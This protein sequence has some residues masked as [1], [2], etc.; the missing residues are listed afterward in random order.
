MRTQ[1]M[2]VQEGIKKLDGRFHSLLQSI[3][4]KPETMGRLG[5]L[6]CR[7]LQNLHTLGDDRAMIRKFLKDGLE[8]DP[9]KGFEHTVEAGKI[10]S[11]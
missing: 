8:L 3:E 6:G 9:A 1:T 2:T 11:A 7:S 10:V 5:E 4:C